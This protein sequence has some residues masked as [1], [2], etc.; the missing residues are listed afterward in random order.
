[1]V[2]KFFQRYIQKAKSFCDPKT[3]TIEYLTLGLVE[4][5]GEIAGKVKRTL[6]GD[7][8]ELPREKLILELG[9]LL[10]YFVLILD[11]LGVNIEQVMEKNLN[12]LN[13][14]KAKNLIR[15]EGDER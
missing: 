5:A 7:Y 4:E 8:P 15:G 9:D 3:Y 6:R 2:S 13:E 11:F 1:M 14:R 12:K 10:W